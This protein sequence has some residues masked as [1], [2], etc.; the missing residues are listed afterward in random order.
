MFDKYEGTIAVV[1]EGLKS[2]KT[3]SYS[4]D[5]VRPERPFR[6]QRYLIN[7]DPRTILSEDTYVQMIIGSGL[8]I[9][10]P[11]N[12]KAEKTLRDWQ[13]DT[14]FDVKL[15]NALHSY[16]GQGQ[17]IFEYSKDYQDYVEVNL[18][19]IDRVKLDERGKWSKI[20]LT[21]GSVSK[22]IELTPKDVK[23]FKLTETNKEIFGRGMFHAI[24]TGKEIDGDYY[25][26]P[27]EA[28]WKIEDAMKKIFQS[29]ASP[30]MMIHFED[31][32]E[33]F[34][35]K[36]KEEF[37]KAKPGAKILTDKEFDVKVFEVNPASKF[38]KYIEHLQ[39]DV[40]EPGVQFPIQYFNAGFTAR[41]ASETTDDAMVRKVKTI[42][43]KLANQL[44]KA[45][46]MPVLDSLGHNVDH[47]DV[48]AVF[49]IDTNTDV[50]LEDVENMFEKG[51]IV[52]NEARDYLKKNTTMK[53]DSAN[54][55][56]T[57][58]ITSVTPTNDKTKQDPRVWVRANLK[59]KSLEVPKTTVTNGDSDANDDE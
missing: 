58:P 4:W 45:F 48:E 41:A 18:N 2:E 40:M 6:E 33:E 29:Y 54:D 14:D 17:M 24:I 37:K 1:N 25:D 7:H 39:N 50:N 53:L 32:G 47:A 26:S 9:K 55:G 51:L 22:E 21:K 20:F 42:Q 34:I 5:E 56:N 15:E 36:Q 52:R 16:I 46:F 8:K 59:G 27:L 35:N 10:I 44:K 13:Y 12:E 38:D 3:Q 23:W 31:A 49:E 57:P 19:E 30:I 43:K 28:L 11:K